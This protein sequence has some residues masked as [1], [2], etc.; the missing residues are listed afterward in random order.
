MTTLWEAK[1]FSDE[2]I[3][4]LAI[5]I[6]VSFYV[7]FLFKKIN[8]FS[9]S[10]VSK[11]V[12]VSIVSL[13]L[14]FNI[15]NIRDRFSEMN[16]AKQNSLT[17]EG[18]VENFEYYTNGSDSFTCDGIYFSY[19]SLESSIGYDIPKRDKKSVI[20]YEGQ[21]VY[22]TYYTRNEENIIIKIQQE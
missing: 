10:N 18:E 5:S 7:I 20:N 4:F 12:G 17:V 21:Y 6:I 22:I 14:I 8:T 9:Q 11:I 3:G 19:P 13:L 2:T 16:Y 15:L 1:V